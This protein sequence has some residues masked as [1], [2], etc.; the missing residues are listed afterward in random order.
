ML[1][2]MSRALTCVFQSVF[3]EA[4]EALYRATEYDIRNSGKP[5]EGLT[6]AKHFAQIRVLVPKSWPRLDGC[7]GSIGGKIKIMNS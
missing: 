7:D 6:S 5:S 3:V 1:I 2:T 4:S